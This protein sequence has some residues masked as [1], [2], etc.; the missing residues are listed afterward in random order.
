[1]VL[2]PGPPYQASVL[3]TSLQAE[4]LTFQQ[5]T[6]LKSVSSLEYFLLHQILGTAETSHSHLN[7][8]FKG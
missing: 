8:D 3:P 5:C 7:P 2:S 6:T 4:A 1:M